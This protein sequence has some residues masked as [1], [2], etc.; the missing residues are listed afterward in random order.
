M[1]VGKARR[2]L[3]RSVQAFFLLSGG[4]QA[5][6][7]GFAYFPKKICLVIRFLS[8][9]RVTPWQTISMAT[10]TVGVKSRS[11]AQRFMSTFSTCGSSSSS[12]IFWTRYIPKVFCPM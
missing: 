3:S 10:D 6:F 4:L 1:S 11:K 12:R 5:A 2:H 9:S 8:R 7:L